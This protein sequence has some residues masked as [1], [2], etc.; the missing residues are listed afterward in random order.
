[1]DVILKL[2]TVATPD[3]RARIDTSLDALTGADGA[4]D[5]SRMKADWFPEIDCDVI[6]THS[7]AYHRLARELAR[8][9]SDRFGV[10]AFVD[11]DLWG[12]TADLQ[13]RIDDR[14]RDADGDYRYEDVRAS[15]AHVH[16]MLMSALA[17][18]MDR[19]ECMLLLNAPQSVPGRTPAA[20]STCSPWIYGE[21][22]LSS[23]LRRRAPCDH[24][25]AD[26]LVFEMRGLQR[27]RYEPPL[28]HL[29]PLEAKDLLRCTA[30]GTVDRYPALD[31]PYR[32]FVPQ[33]L[34]AP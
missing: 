6:L 7:H 24:R 26:G 1:M 13:K 29:C 28:K 14:A 4:L 23:V 3:H 16:M 32:I 25:P 30:E 17:K 34:E 18:M 8:L 2:R 11:A 21:I 19:C 27:F 5:V 15:S 31:W 22:S 12:S 33:Q 9:L 10:R 20:A